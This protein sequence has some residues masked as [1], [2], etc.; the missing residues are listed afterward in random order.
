MQELNELRKNIDEIDDLVLSKLNERMEFVK[1]IGVLKQTSGAPIYRPE[2]EKAIINRLINRK[3]GLLNR[4]AIEAIYLEI[5]AVSRNL[6]MPQKIAYLGPEGTYTHQAAESRFG[7]MSSY[8]PLA[9]I[10]AVFNILAQKEVKYGVVP[11]ENNTEGAVGATLD[12]FRKFPD[13]KIVA[14]LYLD[15]HHSFVSECEN[16]KDIK[17]IYSHPQGYNQCRKFLEDH[18]LLDVE[19]IPSR[20]TAE[21]AYLASK[22]SNSAAICSKIAA[23]LHN[24]PILYDTIEDNMANRT[25][26]FILSDFKNAKAQGSKTSILAKTDHKPGSLVDLLQIFKNENINITK[27]ESRPIKQ[28]EFKSVFYLDFEGHVDDEKVQNVFSLAKECGAEITWLGS[29]LNGDEQ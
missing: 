18:M 19:F 24:V 6:E 11:I 5:F 2:R 4:A 9:T 10:E 13:I 1:K 8:L 29:Y 28:R 23:K 7:A 3:G 12:C 22:N 14:E 15:I 25:R 21:A 17:K 20:S 26:F 27:L 16:I